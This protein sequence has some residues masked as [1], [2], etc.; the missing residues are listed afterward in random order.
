M[1]SSSGIPSTK[2][3]FLCAFASKF[4]PDGTPGQQQTSSGGVGNSSGARLGFIICDD[5]ILEYCIQ[6]IS[7]LLKIPL[8]ILSHS[9]SD[10]FP[11]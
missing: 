4:L 9:F 6:R 8:F 1:W 5:F 11:L 7:S 10:K 2:V 3:G